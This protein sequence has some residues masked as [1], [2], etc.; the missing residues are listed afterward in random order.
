MCVRQGKMLPPT[1]SDTSTDVALRLKCIVFGTRKGK[2]YKLCV[3][4]KYTANCICCMV[5][6]AG[7]CVCV[8]RDIPMSVLICGADALSDIEWGE[9]RT[10]PCAG[11]SKQQSTHSNTYTHIIECSASVECLRHRARANKG[12][13]HVT[14]IRR[15]RRRRRRLAAC[16]HII[17]IHTNIYV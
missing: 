13:N 2:L 17:S 4:I 1:L 6:A 12:K 10:G 11:K 9:S 15:R 7:V 16:I 3:A 8:C 5:Y 14:H